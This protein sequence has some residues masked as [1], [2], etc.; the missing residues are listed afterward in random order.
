FS[1]IGGKKELGG[2]QAPHDVTNL[3]PINKIHFLAY[4]SLFPL[5]AI[6]KLLFSLN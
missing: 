3:L 4:P 5:L 2:F 1:G 6:I